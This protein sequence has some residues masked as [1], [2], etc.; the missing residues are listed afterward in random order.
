MFYFGAGAAFD[1]RN[2]R[3]PNWWALAGTAAGLYI[4][5][6]EFLIPAMAVIVIFF[7]MFLCRMMGAGDI[8]TMALLTGYLGPSLGSRALFAGFLTGGLVSLLKLLYRK[9]LIKRL[10]YFQAYIRRLIHTRKITPYY[11]SNRDGYGITIPFTL[12]LFAGM[13][14]VLLRMKR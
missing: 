11:N 4:K 14:I 8:K 13:C 2:R 3:V 6:W 5:G 9:E 12:C 1:W 7:P 10:I